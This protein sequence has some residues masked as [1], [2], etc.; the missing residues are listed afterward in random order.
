M[1]LSQKLEIFG[2]VVC[3]YSYGKLDGSTARANSLEVSQAA[4]FTKNINLDRQAMYPS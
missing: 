2:P 4:V 1:Q 3:I